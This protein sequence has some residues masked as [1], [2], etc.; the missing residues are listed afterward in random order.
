MTTTSALHDP[1]SSSNNHHHSR[2]SRRHRSRS[3]KRRSTTTPENDGLQDEEVEVVEVEEDHWRPSPTRDHDSIA[4]VRVVHLGKNWQEIGNGQQSVGGGGGG[5]DLMVT[6]S[7]MRRQKRSGG[8][9]G[10]GR[11]P[12]SHSMRTLPSRGGG[13]GGGGSNQPS[14]LRG[15]TTTREDGQLEPDQD[16]EQEEGEDEEESSRFGTAKSYR[17]AQS[18]GT[19]GGSRGSRMG[20]RDIWGT[21]IE[22]EQDGIDYKKREEV[23]RVSFLSCFSSDPEY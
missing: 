2:S 21:A 12:S 1:S 6:P 11:P 16:E 4:P 19:G 17:T 5:G 15:Y 14:P 22:D 8:G 7:T 10:K 13:N 20:L 9:G 18:S 3:S 23:K